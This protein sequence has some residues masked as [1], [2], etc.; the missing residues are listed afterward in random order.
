MIVPIR[1]DK[2]SMNVAVRETLLEV[3]SEFQLITVADTVCFGKALLLDGHIQFTDLDEFAY[4]ESF[5]HIPF[6]SLESA[7]RAL[8]VGGG[9]GGILRELCRHTGLEQID[10][11]E[12]DRAVIDACKEQF[13]HVSCG[14]FNDPRVN[15]TVGDAFPF[16]KNAAAGTYDLILLDSTDTYED[17]NGELSAQ[18]FTQEFYADCQRALSDHGMVVTQADNHVFCPYSLEHIQAEFRRVFERVGSYWALVPS[19]GGFSAFCWASKGA[20]VH[21]VEDSML[22][23]FGMRYLNPSTAHLGLNK[24]PFASPHAAD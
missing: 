22:Y 16:V 1:S 5:V 11:V 17:E 3:Q 2:L 21:W 8:V 7:K 10:I 23:P 9:D 15:L 18:L 12:I 14:A 20:G 24:T 6:L 4:H 19:F 13:P